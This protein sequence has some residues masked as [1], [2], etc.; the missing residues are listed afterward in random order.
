MAALLSGPFVSTGA[1][2]VQL[3][4]IVIPVLVL[5]MI[6]VFGDKAN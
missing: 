6:N 4:L 5:S 3:L 2:I 1:A